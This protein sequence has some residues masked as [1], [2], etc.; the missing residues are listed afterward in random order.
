MHEPVPPRIAGPA[1][2]VFRA[3]VRMND[4]GQHAIHK[5]TLASALAALTEET[6]AHCAASVAALLLEDGLSDAQQLN[7]FVYALPVCT[8][9][10]LLGFEA[11]SLPQLATWTGQFVACLSP[12]SSKQQIEVAHDAA[13]SLLAALRALVAE[14]TIRRT[15]LLGDVE[16]GEWTDSAALLSNLLGLLSQT[17]EA[18]AGLL[19]NCIV[20]LLRGANPIQVVEQTMRVDPG[21][22]NTRRFAAADMRIGEIAVREGETIL[23]VLAAPDAQNSFGYGRHAC[24]GR[25]LARTI[26]AQGLQTLLATQALPAVRWRYRPSANT[27]LPEFMET[28]R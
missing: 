3:L 1:G 20:G 24:P 5:A 2:E 4:G 25:A 14:N 10:H 11:A 23:L 13:E 16:A 8:V 12:L 17:C 18:S 27:R 19:G 21:V 22:H 9:A 6:T 28:S 7:R 26:A 15:E